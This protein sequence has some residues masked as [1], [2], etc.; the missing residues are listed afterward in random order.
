VR[1][2]NRSAFVAIPKEPYLR[3]AAGLDEDALEAAKGLAGGVSVYLVPEHPTG[4]E[5][6]PIDDYYA[7]I[8]ETE[9]DAWSQDESE[10]PLTRDL[11]TFL[12]WFEVRGESIV[13]DLA[14]GQIEVE[15]D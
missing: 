2:L 7:R 4:E 9:L 6:P 1:T 11:V 5:T 3:W 8:F 14:E 13:V 12:A 15:Q 10:W